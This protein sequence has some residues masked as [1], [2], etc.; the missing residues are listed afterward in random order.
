MDRE[1]SIEDSIVISQRRPGVTIQR[2]MCHGVPHMY[3]QRIVSNKFERVTKKR[4]E[5]LK[6]DVYYSMIFT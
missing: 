1:D 2:S 6:H 5:R 4:R 3:L